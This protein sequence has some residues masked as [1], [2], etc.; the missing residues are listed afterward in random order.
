M[1]GFRDRKRNKRKMVGKQLNLDRSI[2][3]NKSRN[4]KLELWGKVSGRCCENIYA[5]IRPLPKN[6]QKDKLRSSGIIGGQR[7]ELLQSEI[8]GAHST[9]IMD[10]GR[11][12]G[13]FGLLG[14]MV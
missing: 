1:A 3:P 10:C 9:K 4:N 14:E 5:C 11:E 6:N 7:R 8:M 12:L 2:L 13:I